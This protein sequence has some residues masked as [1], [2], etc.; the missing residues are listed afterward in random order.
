[1]KKLKSPIKLVYKEIDELKK[2]IKKI[3]N[4]DFSEIKNFEKLC[5]I[6]LK[7]IKNKKKN[8]I[9]WKWRKCCRLS[10]FSNRINC[11]I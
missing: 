5:K 4:N 1:M 3:E 6:C 8:N 7:T 9:F 2:V 11:K 10:T